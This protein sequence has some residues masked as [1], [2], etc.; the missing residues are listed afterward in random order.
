MQSSEFKS[1]E[2]IDMLWD[3]IFDNISSL[4][5]N[6]DHAKQ[7]LI[8]QSKIFY[9]RERDNKNLIDMN[10]KFIS[11]IMNSFSKPKQP[12]NFTIEEL[13]TERMNSFERTLAEKKNEFDNAMTLHVPPQPKFNDVKDEPIGSKMN[14]LI[15]QTVAQ[16]N[17]DLEE[18]HN[19]I[20]TDTDA[21]NWLNLDK[22][23]YMHQK[24]PKLIQIGDRIDKDVKEVT[25]GQNKEY[26]HHDIQ[27]DTQDDTNNIFSKLK[28]TVNTDSLEL[29]HVKIDIL[30]DTMN[31]IL[32]KNI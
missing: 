27:D 20:N 19:G 6:K 13:H 4:I 14:D 22:S 28:R 29:L 9:E 26:I 3:I 7:F 2:N 11:Q 23:N 15:A 1:V 16:R 30:I 17:F 25:W 31:K 10:K 21:N 24:I 32:A 12:V 18:I 8:D 5:D